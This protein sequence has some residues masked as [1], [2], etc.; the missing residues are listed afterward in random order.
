[1]SDKILSCTV[2]KST[3]GDVIQYYVQYPVEHGSLSTSFCV[4]ITAEE[5]SNSSD[6]S[7][8]ITIAN[9]KALATKNSWI[10]NLPSTISTVTISQEQDVVLE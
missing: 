2:E 7:E 1:M 4:F 6:Q 9:G 5:M 8:A 3:N 10:S